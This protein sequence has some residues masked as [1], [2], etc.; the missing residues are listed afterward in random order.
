MDI[1]NNT[2]TH[3]VCKTTSFSTKCTLKYTCIHNGKSFFIQ[4]PV[5]IF[6]ATK[7]STQ[8]HHDSD[9]NNIHI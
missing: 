2:L 1:M 5:G 4:E 6:K 7:R 8:V 9:E 3:H